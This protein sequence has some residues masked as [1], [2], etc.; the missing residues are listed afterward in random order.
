MLRPFHPLWLFS[1]FF[2]AAGLL[3]ALG[4]LGLY[5]YLV[6][7]HLRRQPAT[8]KLVPEWTRLQSLTR[9]AKY[10]LVIG[11]TIQIASFAFR[12]WLEA[13]SP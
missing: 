6:A 4:G 9:L 13:I 1:D 5:A 3:S 7:R 10:L 12:M 8:G 11:V 2:A